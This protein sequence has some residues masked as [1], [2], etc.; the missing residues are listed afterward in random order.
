VKK[1]IIKYSLFFFLLVCFLF[2]FT[3]HTKEGKCGVERTMV[4]VWR[5]QREK[6]GVGD[7]PGWDVVL[8]RKP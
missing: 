7:A 6:E 2:C 3:P 1:V 5:E 4:I 8:K